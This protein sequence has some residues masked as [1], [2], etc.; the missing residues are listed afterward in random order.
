MAHNDLI[1]TEQEAG[2]LWLTLNNPANRNALSSIMIGSLTSALEAA[3]QDDSVRV[4]V[5]TGT[6]P[7]FSAGH[8]LKELDQQAANADGEAKQKVTNILENCAA[9]QPSRGRHD[10]CHVPVSVAKC[11]CDGVAHRARHR[12]TAGRFYP[13]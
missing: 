1:L 3:Y 9:I 4:I 10:G 8:D 7:V 12:R 5:I 2:V 6:G 11:G 13:A